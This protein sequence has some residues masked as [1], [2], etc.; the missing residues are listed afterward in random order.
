MKVRASAH[1]WGWEILKLGHDVRL[2]SPL[3]MQPFVKRQQNDT[4]STRRRSTRRRSVAL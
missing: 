1:Y 4:V 2:M 3:Y